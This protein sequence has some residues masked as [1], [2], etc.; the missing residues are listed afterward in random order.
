MNICEILWTWFT[1]TQHLWYDLYSWIHIYYAQ[2]LMIHF[3]LV[4]SIQMTWN[5]SPATLGQITIT[6]SAHQMAGWH[7]WCLLHID[8]RKNPLINSVTKAHLQRYWTVIIHCVYEEYLVHICTHDD[9]IKWKHFPHYWSFV[10]RIH[11]PLVNFPSQRPVTWSFDLF[12]DLY[13]NKH[14][15]KQSRCWWI[16]TVSRSLWR[17]SN[18]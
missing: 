13:L 4:T 18:V 14:V 15:S 5:S 10:W 1:C 11:W 6:S 8:W 17:Q 2:S 3:F 9:V 16:G 7:V 12:F